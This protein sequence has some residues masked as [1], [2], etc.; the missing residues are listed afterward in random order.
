MLHDSATNTYVALQS[1][2]R[3]PC[4]HARTRIVKDATSQRQG[5][6]WRRWR[7][8]FTV[9]LRETGVVPC[10]TCLTRYH[11]WSYI[12]GN[13]QIQASCALLS[14]M[15]MLKGILHDSVSCSGMLQSDESQ[16][17]SLAITGAS[18]LLPPLLSFK[19]K[20]SALRLMQ[21]RPGMC[22]Q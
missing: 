6:V 20:G 18:R 4:V 9:W 12:P 5:K 17:A 15:V 19:P 1:I 8:D 14:M 7:K 3:P 16:T 22:C 21:G 13:R 11:C 2:H 10:T